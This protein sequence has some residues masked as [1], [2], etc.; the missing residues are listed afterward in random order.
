MAG[1][2]Y[3]AN[4][5][6]DIISVNLNN[7][8]SATQLAARALATPATTVNLPVAAFPIKAN[9]DK[10]VFGGKGNTNLVIINFTNIADPMQFKIAIDGSVTGQDLYFYIFDN[11]LVGQNAQGTATGI[12]ITVVPAPT[13]MASAAKSTKSTKKN[14][15]TKK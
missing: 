2:A 4:G 12:T 3:F 1:T 9:K 14:T 11:T 10:G 13:L 7:A 6:N 8:L 5:V 15:T